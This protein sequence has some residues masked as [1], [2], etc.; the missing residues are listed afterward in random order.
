MTLKD[1]TNWWGGKREPV[2]APA[3]LE[4]AVES[5][6]R[7]MNQAFANF[8]RSFEAGPFSAGFGMEGLTPRMDVADT[9]NAV[10]VS[11]E[12]PGLEEKDVE[13]TIANGLLTVKAE[14]KAE[15][16]DRRAGYHLQERS[17]GQVR[18]TVSLP[19][20]VDGD[21]A[22]AAFHNGVLKVKVPKTGELTGDVKR[23]AVKRA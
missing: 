11:V 5:L 12:L 14:K 1:L 22:E 21:R 19:A 9:G 8:W 18:R 13:V 15:R 10:E 6:H 17:Y 20:N 2:P 16:E 3:D 4:T 23:I 7:D